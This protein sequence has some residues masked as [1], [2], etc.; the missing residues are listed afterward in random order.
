M[1]KKIENIKQ[2]LKAN[3][4]VPL[5]LKF[6]EISPKLVYGDA[7][8]VDRIRRVKSNKLQTENYFVQPFRKHISQF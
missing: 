8:V 6:V 4:Q 3:K 1:N 5:H 7:I 2:E